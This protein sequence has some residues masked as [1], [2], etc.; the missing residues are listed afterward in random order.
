[1]H[2]D[3][4][5][6]V[7]IESERLNFKT[8]IVDPSDKNWIENIKKGIERTFQSKILKRLFKELWLQS[9]DCS[10]PIE[11]M[12]FSIQEVAKCTGNKRKEIRK[13]LNLLI[14]NNYIELMSKE[15]LLYEF[16][17]KGKAIKTNLEIESII[18]N[19]G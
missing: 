16:T 6:G 18:K 13:Y 3:D 8:I 19:I 11:N 15:S 14:D 12:W 7:G 4:L 2:I 1:M 10:K 5:K 17:K 9:D